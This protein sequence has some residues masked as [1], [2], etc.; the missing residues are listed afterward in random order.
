M[1]K[2]DSTR[3]WDKPK[4][5]I[6]CNINEQ[7]LEWVKPKTLS[8]I[9]KQKVSCL[10]KKTKIY[11]GRQDA[12]TLKK[13]KKILKKNP[14]KQIYYGSGWVLKKFDNKRI[15]KD[16]KGQ[17]VL[18]SKKIVSD[19]LWD[20]VA[21]AIR[22]ARDLKISKK[23]ILKAISNLQFDG[24]LQYIRGRLTKKL[25]IREKL[26]IDGCH[27]ISSAKNLVNYLKNIKEDVYGIWG[28]Q[29]H[30]NPKLFIKEFK[31]IFK[32]IITVE[33]PDEPNSC[34]SSQLKN[35]AEN[36][37]IKCKTSNNIKDAIKM[38]SNKKPKVI[39][40]FGSLYLIGKVIS[41][42]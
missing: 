1:F 20:N 13:I 39:V 14:S 4:C 24:R 36:Y 31:G 29:K 27:S 25:S 34:K 38:L 32:K 28:M 6:V 30:K 3:V 35:I 5:Q 33:I 42:N 21:L 7:H 41:L 17:I 23:N 12:E 11:I 37:N 16:E 9:I 10:S 15:Y 8:E 26:L 18:K 40:C 2:G 22:V 19:G